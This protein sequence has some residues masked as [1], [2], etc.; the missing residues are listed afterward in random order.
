MTACSTVSIAPRARKVA[1]TSDTIHE[2]SSPPGTPVAAAEAALRGA[3]PGTA[4]PI[5]PFAPVLVVPVSLPPALLTPGCPFEA[6][7]EVKTTD[8]ALVKEY[9]LTGRADLERAAWI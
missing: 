2:R 4:L 8:A 9:D 5:T 3:V 6:E 1:E 7:L